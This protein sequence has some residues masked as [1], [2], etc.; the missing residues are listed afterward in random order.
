V[1]LKPFLGT[2]LCLGLAVPI[3]AQEV[4]QGPPVRVDFQGEYPWE[5]TIRNVDGGSGDLRT[6]TGQGPP[7]RMD[8]QG[9]YPWEVTIRNADMSPGDLRTDAEQGPPVRMDFQGEYPWEVTIRNAETEQANQ[10]SN[11]QMPMDTG[12]SSPSNRDKSN[13]PPQNNQPLPGFLNAG[14]AGSFSSKDQKGGSEVF[15]SGPLITSYG[16]GDCVPLGAYLDIEGRDLGDRVGSFRPYLISPIDPNFRKQRI[17][18]ANWSDTGMR[19]MIARTS[20][21]LADGQTPYTIRF[22]NARTGEWVGPE[23][24]AFVFCP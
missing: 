21:I 1:R 16:P 6:D 2:V 4:Q 17:I 13:T 22:F 12:F 24:P 20:R 18:V 19:I 8:F 14:N 10:Q 3:W 7:V 11:T 9:E 5:V 23:N 15:L